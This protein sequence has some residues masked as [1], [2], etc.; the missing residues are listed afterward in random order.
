MKW[1]I[2]AMT[3]VTLI[4]PLGSYAE[5]RSKKTQPTT[6]TTNTSPQIPADLLDQTSEI[7]AQVAENSMPATVS[8]K[9]IVNQQQQQFLNPFDM[10]GDEFFR[11]FFG[12][13]FPNQLQ[14]QQP[15]PQQQMT[16]GSGFLVSSDG[17]IVTN[18]HVIQEAVQITVTLND[19]R[20]YAA[21]ARST[22]AT[23]EARFSI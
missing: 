15:Q 21:T 5:A 17:Y 22:Q 2:C 13:Q 9:G 11:R 14:P 19:G 7:F 8:I 18:N 23:P 6:T 3:A 10:F 12:G 20:E 1:L 16:G 4:C